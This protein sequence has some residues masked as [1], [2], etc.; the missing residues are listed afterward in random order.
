MRKKR[1]LLV[2]ISLFTVI[3]FSFSVSMAILEFFSYMEYLESEN[4]TL[5]IVTNSPETFVPEDVSRESLNYPPE[6][7]ALFDKFKIDYGIEVSGPAYVGG[8]NT[9]NLMWSYEEISAVYVS[10]GKLPPDF[11]NN[12]KTPLKIY[13]IKPQGTYGGPGGSYSQYYRY[14]KLYLPEGYVL[15]DPPFGMAL[16]LF[17]T[18]AREIEGVVMHEYAHSY[19]AANPGLYEKFAVASGWVWENGIWVYKGEP[20][21]F[22]VLPDDPDEDFANAVSTAGN[23]PS[24]LTQNTLRFFVGFYPINNWN[25]FMD[26]VIVNRPDLLVPN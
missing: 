4:V 5:K 12:S 3:I 14:M 11:L 16:Q 10:L 25:V 19:V 9:P 21:R 15:S 8:N 1:F 17:G 18:S 24:H 13:L 26:W 7:I 23:N 2:L 22:L 20:F 6:I